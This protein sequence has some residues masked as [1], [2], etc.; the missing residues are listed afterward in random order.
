MDNNARWK[1]LLLLIVV[2][3]GGSVWMLYPPTNTLRLGLD[4]SGGAMLVYEVDV[5]QGANAQTIVAQTIEVLKKRVDPRGVMNL[6]WRPLAGNR[7]EVQ[8][9]APSK[10]LK[11]IRDTY[12]DKFEALI[13]KNISKGLVQRVL[14][15]PAEQRGADLDQIVAGNEQ[16]PPLLQALSDT[17]DRRH[18]AE[19]VADTAEQT[20]RQLQSRL[21]GLPDEASRNDLESQVKEALEKSF[22]TGLQLVETRRA[23]GAAWATVLKT[24]VNP[25]ELDNV[26]SLSDQ[27]GKRLEDGKYEPS[28]RTEALTK[29][30]GRYPKR[31]AAI[32]DLAKARKEYDKVKGPLE[33]P[34]DLVALLRGSGVLEFRIAVQ[35]RGSRALPNAEEFRSEL[36]EKGPTKDKT[37]LYLW[38]VIDDLTAFT[39]SA[40]EFAAAHSDPAGYFDRDRNLVA[41]RFGEDVY[42]LLSNKIDET[43]TKDFADHRGWEL[44]QA[45]VTQDRTGLRAVSFNLNTRG[46]QL[47]GRLTANHINE[48]MTILLD[49]LVISAP[50]IQGAIGA[51][52]IITGGRGGFAESEAQYLIRTLNAGSLQAGVKGPISVQ[53][54][55]AKFGADNLDRGLKA[56]VAAM[57]VVASFMAAYYMVNG[58]IANVALFGNMAM[59]LG[60]MSVNFLGATFT[61]PG[62]AAIVLTIGMAVDANVLIFER[63]REEL[64]RGADI[65]PAVRTGYG[66]ALATIIDANLTT[67]ITCLVLGYTATTEVRGFAVT[68]GIGILA[69]LFTALLCTRVLIEFS[70]MVP[71]FRSLPMIPTLVPSIGRLLRPNVDWAGKR[72]IFFVLSAAIGIGGLSAVFS[73]G[74]DMLDIEFRSGTQVGFEL[75][76]DAAPMRIADVKKRLTA[77]AEVHEIPELSGDQVKVVALGDLE[78]NAAKSFKVASLADNTNNRVSEAVKAAFKDVLDEKL[79]VSFAHDDAEQAG[80]WI[81]PIRVAELGPNID[82]PEVLEEQVGQYIGGVAIV[83]DDI[84]PPITIGDAEARIKRSRFQP[85]HDTYGYRRV[86]IIG[87]DLGAGSDTDPHY[88][89]LAIVTYDDKTNYND[90]PSGIDEPGGLAQTE[91]RLVR[92]ALTLQSSLAS[93]SSFSPQVSRTMQFN[94]IYAVSLSLLAVVAYIWLRF[95]SIRYG[96]AAIVALVHDVAIALGLIAVAASLA[97]TPIGRALLLSDFKIDLTIVAAMLTIVGYS[98]NDTIVIFDRIRENRGRLAHATPA[99]INDSINQT[100]SRTVLTSLTTG[101]ALLTLYIFGGEGVHGFAFAMLIGVV[102]GTYSSVAI[103]APIVL[104]AAQPDETSALPAG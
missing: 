75:R 71:S 22:A 59:I 99:I 57:V 8:M 79:A 93:V 40:S 12:I 46:G 88:K 98:L 52:G 31:G 37:S 1:W 104:V 60:I 27:P 96:L 44:A 29:L 85:P 41:E 74:P 87:L 69:T 23:V 3:L 35:S 84:D 92:H 64:E 54:F 25:V 73:R 72:Y 16:M 50:N 21:D 33:D 24:N 18:D 26:L 2:V 65:R 80:K 76:Q 101:M 4:L 5:P 86:K 30:I 90:D 91:W 14:R 103:A 34:E 83:I 9:P 17:L 13:D 97:D 47:M 56:A 28:K 62:I 81:H 42:L 49:G 7:F 32:R 78:D 66:K 89:S 38:C 67:L 10:N 100:F 82:R 51:S 20:H 55:N 68:L 95:G 70:L 43:L 45:S 102:V 36:R 48:P 61:L 58:L 6:V 77:I 94:A 63:I 15:L 39:D 53:S 19:R 11:A